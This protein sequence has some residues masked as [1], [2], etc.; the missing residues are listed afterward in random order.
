[1]MVGHG[2]DMRCHVCGSTTAR[3]LIRST[4]TGIRVDRCAGCDLAFVADAPAIAELSAEEAAVR[5]ASYLAAQRTGALHDRYLTTLGRLKSILPGDKPKLFDVGAGAGNFLAL[6]ADEG[7][8]PSGNEIS[9]AA[10]VAARERHG[11]DL[12]DREM[13]ELDLTSEFDAVTMWCV[14]AHVPDPAGLLADAYRLLRPGG[15]LYFHTP[16]WCA[17][18]VGG[19]A[20]ARASAG[21]LSHVTDRRINRSHRWLYSQVNLTKLLGDV[22][23]VPLRV[24]PVAGYSLNT[25]AY[26]SAMSFPVALREPVAQ[27]ADTLIRRG[28]FARNILDVYAAK[29]GSPPVPPQT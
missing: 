24:D 16:R 6:A 15:V 23:F 4:R 29:P 7:F 20:L 28:W 1:M 11:I 14:L 22:G 10:I 2:G 17:I 25:T 19:L 3:K 27:V 5:Y 9:P 26:L 12:H 8:L 18:D 13:S 21:H